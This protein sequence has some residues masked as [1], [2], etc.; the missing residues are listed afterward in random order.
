MTVQPADDPVHSARI[1]VTRVPAYGLIQD[2]EHVLLCR[3]SD[4][5]PDHAGMWTLP[6]GGLEFGEDPKAG[7]VREVFEETGFQVVAS[8]LA[9]IDSITAEI[10]GRAYHGIRILYHVEV[11]GGSLRNELHGTTDLCQWHR[12]DELDQLGLVDLV[13]AALPLMADR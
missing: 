5:I 13:I 10:P 8:R 6:G 12:K 4:Q 7:M 9:D 11:I 2:A 3:I 1:E